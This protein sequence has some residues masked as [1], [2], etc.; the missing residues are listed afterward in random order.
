MKILFLD[1]DRNTEYVVQDLEK[2]CDSLHILASSWTPAVG[3]LGLTPSDTVFLA[4]NPDHYLELMAE[5]QE[6]NCYDYIF[7]S[8]QDSMTAALGR[9]NDRFGLPGISESTAR[10][11]D[12]KHKYYDIFD[13]LGI[14]YPR[15]YRHDSI[16][17]DLR[18]PCIVKP[19]DGIGNKDVCI[20]NDGKQL[21]SVIRSRAKGYYLIQEYIAGTV[22]SLL[23]HVVSREI[24]ID[25]IY[26]IEPGL[27]PYTVELGFRFPSRYKG[28][29]EEQ[30]TVHL[31]RF[32]DHIGLDNSV[33]MLDVIVQEDQLYLIDFA[34]RLSRNSMKPIFY[35]GERAYG[36]KLANRLARSVP[37]TMESHSM[38]LRRN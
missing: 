18:F 24:S 2:H 29:I 17:K 38:A 32:F 20:V 12:R 16:S 15:T 25:S 31:E 6:Q 22:C 27:P 3:E 26:D 21:L 35:T 14:P 13:R 4:E 23:G 30:L 33:F 34:A 36:W 28:M 37:F 7:P 9:M 10:M 1:P 5:L 19:T 8:Q 11:I